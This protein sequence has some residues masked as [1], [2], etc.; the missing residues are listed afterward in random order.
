MRP[1]DELVKL[2]RLVTHGITVSVIQGKK[3]LDIGSRH[4]VG[5]AGDQFTDRGDTRHQ[6]RRRDA[7]FAV[8]GS[9]V[10]LQI[11]DEELTAATVR[12]HKAEVLQML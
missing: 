9:K 2:L 1:V 10:L 8:G 4:R 11:L 7:F 5:Q 12:E 3:H 6:M